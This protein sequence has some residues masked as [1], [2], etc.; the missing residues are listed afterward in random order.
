[1][2]IGKRI[3]QARKLRSMSLRD[4]GGKVG[5]SQSAIQ[6]YEKD[7]NIP[8]SKVLINL[9]EAL[10]VRIE[11]FFRTEARPINLVSPVYYRKLSKMGKKAQERL[12]AEIKSWLERFFEIEDIVEDK[13]DFKIPKINLEVK[14]IEDVERIAIDLRKEWELGLDSIKSVINLFE[15]R[16]IKIIKVEKIDGFDSCAFWVEDDSRVPVIAV[17]NDISIVRER[18][19]LLHEL[20]HLILKISDDLNEEKVVH[21]F[22]GA[23]LIPE[24]NMKKEL[25]SKRN[26]ISLEELK[27]LKQKYGISMKALMMRA[28]DLSI[29]SENYCSIFFKR[30]NQ[31]GYSKKEPL[32]SLSDEEPQRLRFLVSK[33]FSQGVISLLKASELLDIPLEQFSKEFT[34]EHISAEA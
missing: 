9:A 10:N 30:M 17:K 34:N 28:K 20:G 22:A 32:D 27:I 19:D 23:F 13:I 14:R 29:I 11:F 8:S 12:E 33:A 4:L 25:G 5:V 21:R 24:S 2:S 16:G 26:N 1:M 15:D 18:F 6:N 31:F 3:S 7:K